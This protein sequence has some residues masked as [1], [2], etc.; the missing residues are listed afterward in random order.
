MAGSRGGDKSM[1]V[2]KPAERRTVDEERGVELRFV[3]SGPDRPNIFALTVAGTPIAFEASVR[4]IERPTEGRKLVWTVH[5]VGIGHPFY[6]LPAHRFVD[7]DDRSAVLALIDEVLRVY[8]DLH[9]MIASPVEDVRF[10][11]AAKGP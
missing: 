8:R 3:A 11:P 7:A 2:N 1:F 10:E 6:G 9:G 5:A 4:N